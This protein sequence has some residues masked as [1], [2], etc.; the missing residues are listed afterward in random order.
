MSGIAAILAQVSNVGTVKNIL[1]IVPKV[2]ASGPPARDSLRPV[3]GGHR[4]ADGGWVCGVAAG[5]QCNAR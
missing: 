3:A 5:A 4:A 1:S 2:E